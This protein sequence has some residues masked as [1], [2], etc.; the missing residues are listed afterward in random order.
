MKANVSIERLHELFAY[1]AETGELRW[2]VRRGSKAAGAMAGTK[3]P[4]KG[5][6]YIVV[7]I[8]GG[9]HQGHRVVWALLYGEWPQQPI[10]HA[11]GD[12]LN[13][14]PGNLRLA[15]PSQ[16]AVNRRARRKGRYPRGVKYDPR[17][18]RYYAATTL[19]FKPVHIGT[20]LTAEDAAAAYDAWAK[21][22]HGEFYTDETY[23]ESVR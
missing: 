22:V 19:N 13:N 9:M 6:H 2:R 15:T 1:S 4:D 11:D 12:G 17:N 5:R 3:H 21:R 20:F 14:R 7:Q 23:K 18:N 8:D 16:N 10:D